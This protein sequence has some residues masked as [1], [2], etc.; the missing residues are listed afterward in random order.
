MTDLPQLAKATLQ[1]IRWVDGTA[2]DM[3]ARGNKTSPFQI[4]FNPQTL[5]VNRSNQ[6]AGGD[7]PTGSP[8]QFVGKDTTKLTLELVFDTTR[9]ETKGPVEQPRDVRSLTW[10]VANLMKPEPKR[11]GKGKHYAPPGVRFQ[12]GSFNF[13]GVLDS[14]DETLDFFS[15]QGVPLRA[16]VSLSLSGQDID[17][18]RIYGGAD[19]AGTNEFKAAQNGASLQQMVGSDGNQDWKPVAVANGIEMPRRLSPGTLVSMTGA[20]AAVGSAALG[21]DRRGGAALNAGSGL[22]A[23]GAAGRGAGG[24]GEGPRGEGS[25]AAASAGPDMQ[26]GH[27]ASAGPGASVSFR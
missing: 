12:W 15:S 22:D 16:T 1:K 8:V 14:M 23:S 19:G 24:T 13:E 18:K 3:D 7:Q 4:Q 25:G 10:E 11:E 27:G 2:Q 17:F 21:V 6:K 9:T 5:R 20:D 26:A